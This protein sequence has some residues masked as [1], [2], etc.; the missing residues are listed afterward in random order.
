MELEGQVAIVTG[1]GRG[2]GRA[3]ALELFET[4]RHRLALRRGARQLTVAS[5]R[6]LLDLREPRLQ[7]RLA[8]GELFHLALESGDASLRGE[9][10]DEQRVGQQAGKDEAGGHEEPGHRRARAARHGRILAEFGVLL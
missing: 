4:L 7:L 6:A 1:G 3:T 9:V 2:I 10:P 8:G 5:R